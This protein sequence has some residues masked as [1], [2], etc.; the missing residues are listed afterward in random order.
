[1]D[2]EFSDVL[3]DCKAK[4]AKLREAM[5]KSCLLEFFRKFAITEKGGQSFEADDKGI[6]GKI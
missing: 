4:Y 3:N 2:N 5:S 1:M 6:R